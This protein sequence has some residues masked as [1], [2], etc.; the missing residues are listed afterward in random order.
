MNE[1][2]IVSGTFNKKANKERL[3]R[4][5]RANTSKAMRVWYCEG[6]SFSKRKTPTQDTEEN[7]GA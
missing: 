1:S 3:R 2:K 6:L 4:L 5:R 7:A